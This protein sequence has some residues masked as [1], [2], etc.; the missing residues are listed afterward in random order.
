M[1][2]VTY[3][4]GENDER[5]WGRWEV[6]DTGDAFVVKRITV[7]P[8]GV[9]S[10][11]RHQHRSEHWVI[12]TGRARVTLDERTLDLEPGAHVHIP[13]GSWH[14][15]ANPGGEPMEFVEVQQ[16]DELDENDIER[17]DDVYGRS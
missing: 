2:R 15:I 7:V 3:A 6:L 17:R 16:G 8:D 11:Q 4:R 5:P 13:Q 9:L 12:V 14:R 1:A 10:L